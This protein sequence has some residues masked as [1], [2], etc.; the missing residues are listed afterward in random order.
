MGFDGVKSQRFRN[1]GF[2]PMQI[3][4]FEELEE[5]GV[6]FSLQDDIE[7]IATTVATD[8]A[9]DVATTTAT[10]VATSTATSVATSTAT[11]VATNVANALIAAIPPVPVA[12]T[13]SYGVIQKSTSVAAPAAL[14]STDAVGLPLL[15]TITDAKYNQ[16]RADVV[17]IRTTLANLLTELKAATRIM[18]P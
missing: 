9:E 13:S 17:A 2:S 8:V 10:G 3:R 11:T 18:S 15:G 14:T 12:T 16:L 5:V 4:M 7:L 1:A 6:P